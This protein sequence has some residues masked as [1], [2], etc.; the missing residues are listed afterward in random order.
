M[1]EGI[2]VLALVL[3]TSLLILTVRQLCPPVL[4]DAF[5]FP[6]PCYSGFAFSS[7]LYSKVELIPIYLESQVRMG[8]LPCSAHLAKECCKSPWETEGAYSLS[9]ARSGVMPG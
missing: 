3:G 7:C 9:K 4:L 1:A 6:T 2:V 8:P 5:L